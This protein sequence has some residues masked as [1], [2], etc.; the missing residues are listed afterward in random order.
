ML[1][2]MLPMHPGRSHEKGELIRQIVDIDRV[3]HRDG[4][5]R[6]RGSGGTEEDISQRADDAVITVGQEPL[7]ERR[8]IA[9]SV[10]DVTDAH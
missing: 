3:A 2:G 1:I 4:F 6:S 9:G 8:R 5:V 10:S 7:A